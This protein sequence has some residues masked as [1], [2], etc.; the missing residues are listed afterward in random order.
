MTP[1]Y[2]QKYNKKTGWKNADILPIAAESSCS[3]FL[4][5]VILSLLKQEGMS[6]NGK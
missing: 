4:S 5:S 2:R 3:Y 1:R 6:W